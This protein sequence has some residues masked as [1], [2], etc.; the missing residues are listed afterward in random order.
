MFVLHKIQNK[1]KKFMKQ[2][3]LK[4]MLAVALASAMVFSNGGIVQAIDREVTI[5][6]VPTVEAVGA[7]EGTCGV[8]T[9]YT[10]DDNGKLIIS[11]TGTIERW[12]FAHKSAVK[13]V[14][15]E[16]RIKVWILVYLKSVRI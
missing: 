1:E 16:K 11:G 2:R 14:V 8:N 3:N 4:A 13:E 7:T 12:A 6:G 10:L 15:I 9:S 5:H